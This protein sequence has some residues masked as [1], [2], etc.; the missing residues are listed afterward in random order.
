[1]S[2]EEDTRKNVLHM[3][4]SC[5]LLSYDEKAPASHQTP[6]VHR[7]NRLVDVTAC[8]WTST[9]LVSVRQGQ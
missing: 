6:L 8:A 9:V 7:D 1:M 3:E 4:A 2:D 5:E